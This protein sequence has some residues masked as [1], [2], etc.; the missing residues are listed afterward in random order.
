MFQVFFFF[1]WFLAE[2]FAKILSIYLFIFSKKYKNKNI[3]F[4]V[5]KSI[6]SLRKIILGKSDAWST[7]R[8]SNRPSD[9]AWIYLRLADFW[10]PV[11][12]IHNEFSDFFMQGGIECPDQTNIYL[13]VPN[14]NSDNSSL[15]LLTFL[16]LQIHSIF[17][18][19]KYV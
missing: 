3:E 4:W 7:I 6:K 11:T 15:T 16:N 9:P 14:F 2:F 8:L 17:L 18:F 5:P 12:A 13:T 10:I 1:S 19:D